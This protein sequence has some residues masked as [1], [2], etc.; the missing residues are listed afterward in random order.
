MSSYLITMAMSKSLGQWLG[1]ISVLVALKSKYF[2]KRFDLQIS[3][4]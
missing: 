3:G 1:W 4:E 2:G